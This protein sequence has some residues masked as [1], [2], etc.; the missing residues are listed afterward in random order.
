[1]PKF[2]KCSKCGETGIYPNN[3]SKIKC[4]HCG[5]TQYRERPMK[6]YLKD[7]V[8]SNDKPYKEEKD[9]DK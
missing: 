1:M 8:L 9:G 7:K 5:H 4:K 6:E 2:L 3:A